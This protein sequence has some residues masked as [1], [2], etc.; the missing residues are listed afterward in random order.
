MAV[1]GRIGDLPAG[2]GQDLRQM[3]AV[4]R[5]SAQG[6]A[7]VAPSVQVPVIP[8]V[9]EALGGED[10]LGGRVPG[11]AVVEHAQSAALDQGVGDILKLFQIR[12]AAGG[13]ENAHAPRHLGVA[14][15]FV[16]Q[17]LFDALPQGCD[18]LFE[19]ARIDGAQQGMRRQ[20]GMKF[21]IGRASCRERV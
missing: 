15:M 9:D 11:A 8:V 4:Q 5:K 14:G 3:Q 13:L 17:D 20:Q 7:P 10:A 18:V 2:F 6:P 19:Q 12:L 1:Q 16:A 21:E